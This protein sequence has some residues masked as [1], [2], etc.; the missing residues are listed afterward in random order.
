MMYSITH[1][2]HTE[3]EKA[4]TL[5]KNGYTV[6]TP[7]IIL[8]YSK[9]YIYKSRGYERFAC[10]TKTVTGCVT[11]AVTVTPAFCANLLAQ[12]LSVPA[13]ARRFRALAPAEFRPMGR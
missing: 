5:R 6:T 12:P 11:G 13:P 9:K 10:V 7:L 1:I 2:T 3:P 8:F 4:K